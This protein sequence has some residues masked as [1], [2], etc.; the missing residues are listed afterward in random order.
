MK[1]L[2]KTVQYINGISTIQGHILGGVLLVL[3]VMIVSEVVMRYF[4]NA[5][6]IWSTELQLFFYAAICVLSQSYALRQRSH[7]RID[8]LFK[9][10]S[11]RNQEILSCV[12]YVIFF[13]PFA[14]VLLYYGTLFAIH[15]WSIREASVWSSWE[16]ILYPIKTALPIGAF[17]ML[18]QGLSELM[19]HMINVIKGD[20]DE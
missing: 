9:K 4:F 14:C 15:S 10:L 8:L 16:P 7:A 13:M 17:F 11:P 18:V 19:G 6:T 2:E 20:F 1:R 12:F 5:P 3:V